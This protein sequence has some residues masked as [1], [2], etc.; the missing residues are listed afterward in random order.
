M[1]GPLKVFACRGH[2]PFA[3]AVCSHMGCK[4]GDMEVIK[5]A[6]D[7]L[8]VR[9]KENVRECDVFVIQTSAPPVNEGLMELLI[10]LDAMKHSSARRIT[11]VIPYL[12]YARSDKKDQP[13]ISIAARLVAD[14]LETAGADRIL[15]MD[16]HSPQ[17]AGFFRIPLDQLQA[18]PILAGYFAGTD[19]KNTV[20]VASDA[21]EAKDIGRYANRLNLPIAII[22]KRRRGND[23]RAYPTNLVGEVSGMHAL[24]T[25]DEI[26][27]GGTV[28]EAAAFLMERGALSVRVGATHGVLAGPA[29]SRLR[30]SQITEIVVTD[31]VPIP[32]EKRFDRLRVLS[33]APLFAEAITHIH[34]G[35]SVSALFR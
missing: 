19:L 25:D 6:N 5:F 33:V 35:R 34:D 23:D 13:R 8:M 29:V 20:I 17:V 26:S 27:T 30:E 22:D 1:D 16:L 4:P 10:T 14:L 2:R 24:L 28:V 18:A 12:P 15:T 9:V 11:A 31:T 32:D 7:N 21:G 3:E